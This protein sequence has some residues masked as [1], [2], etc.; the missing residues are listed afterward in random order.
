MALAALEALGAARQFG[1]TP[2]DYRYRTDGL[3]ELRKVMM[4][5]ALIYGDRQASLPAVTQLE[6]LEYELAKAMRGLTSDEPKKVIGYTLG[7]GEPNLGAA[8][9]PLENLR[10]QLLDRYAFVPVEIGGAS[11][12]PDDVDALWVVGPQKQLS[13]RFEKEKAQR[14]LT[15]WCL[16]FFFFSTCVCEE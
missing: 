3:S 15:G 9:G 7:N 10:N 8:R 11:G 2:I 16:L 5:V 1:I 12:V 6:T 14:G 4:G 13:D